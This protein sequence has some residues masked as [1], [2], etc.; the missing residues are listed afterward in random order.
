MALTTHIEAG[1]QDKMKTT[2]VFVDLS[3]AF[4]TVWRNGLLLKLARVI[5][6]RKTIELITSMLSNRIF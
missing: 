2:V 6:C 4:D 1:F 5:K 3:S